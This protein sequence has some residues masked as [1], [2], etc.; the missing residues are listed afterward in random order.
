MTNTGE[1]WYTFFIFYMKNPWVI[2][3]ITVVVLVGGSVWYSIHESKTYN[4][5]VILTAHTKGTPSAPVKLIEYSDFECPACKTFQ[6]YVEDILNQFG[7]S[8]YFE[9]RHFPLLQVHPY[10]EAAAVAAEAA[11]QQGKFF[12]YSQLLFQNQDIWAPQNPTATYFPTPYFEQYAK[13]L[14]LDVTQFR[15]Q[16]R[17]ALIREAVKASY[18][19]AFNVKK[20]HSTPSFFL[21]GQLM[22]ITSYQDFKDQVAT[23]VRP[24]VDFGTGD[25]SVVTQ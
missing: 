18:N 17:S 21:N 1:V 9:Y 11:G 19:E 16:E 24:S 23:A 13:E 20:L 5:G 4:E 10:A 25:S 8:I 6:P 15:R 22:N 3:S 12:E 7:D 14:G 2:I